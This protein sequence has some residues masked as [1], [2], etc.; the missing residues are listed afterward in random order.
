MTDKKYREA[1]EIV[2]ALEKIAKYTDATLEDIGGR[3]A[4][5][6]PEV[7]AKLNETLGL[8]NELCDMSFSERAKVLA[9]A[10]GFEVVERDDGSMEFSTEL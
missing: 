2:R 7:A 5:Y 10:Y 1:V 9:E 8:Y 6:R 4:V 3:L